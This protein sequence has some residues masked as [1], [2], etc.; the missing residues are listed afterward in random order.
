M[1]KIY[2]LLASKITLVQG[3]FQYLGEEEGKVYVEGDGLSAPFV[4]E[5]SLPHN[6]EAILQMQIKEAKKQK[7]NELNDAC[8][9]KL[10]SFKSSALGAEHIYDGSLEDQ[11][12]LMGAVAMNKDMHFRCAK[13]GGSKTNVLHTKAQLKQLYDDWLNYK[14]EI[15]LECGVLKSHV[16]SLSSI[17]EIEGVSW[18]SYKNMQ[19]SEKSL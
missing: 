9:V 13:E 6:L 1:K 5:P 14:A 3:N 15:I 2:S 17:Q 10:K 11:L 7:I 16:E 12:N 8:D 4:E 19:G 18:D